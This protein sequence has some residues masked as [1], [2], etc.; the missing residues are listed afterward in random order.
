MKKEMNY[1]EKLELAMEMG[2]PYFPKE[3]SREEKEIKALEMGFPF[4]PNKDE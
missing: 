1:Q 4:L 2:F 3:E